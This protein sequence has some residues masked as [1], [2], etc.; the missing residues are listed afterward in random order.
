MAGIIDTVKL[1]GVLVLAL[2]AAMAGVEL[3]VVRGR[4]GPGAALLF[5]AVGL[6]VVQQRLTTPGD[7]PELVVKR[8]GSGLLDDGDP[9]DGDQR[10]DPKKNDER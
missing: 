9:S 1:A 6:V 3:L 7:V 4:T 10:H 8:I 5:L 2:P